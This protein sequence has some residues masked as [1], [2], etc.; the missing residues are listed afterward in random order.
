[1]PNEQNL[2]PS[3]Y[4]LSQEEAKKG[5]IKSGETRRRK[6]DMRA[7]AQAILDNEYTDKNGQTKTG[8]EVLILNLFKIATDTKNKQCISAVKTLMEL[9]GQS[10]DPI[11]IKKIE[12]EIKL[13]EAKQEALK[14]SNA[15]QSSEE[16]PQLWKA[17]GIEQ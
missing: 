2:R 13:I 11:D 12:A 15:L 6:A 14:D 17:L 8:A 16:L 3:E 7:A 5:G 1:M 4:K 9:T 10:K